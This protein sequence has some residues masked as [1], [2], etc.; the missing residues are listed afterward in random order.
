[1][2]KNNKIDIYLH[3][4]SLKWCVCVCV[5]LSR[6][7]LQGPSLQQQSILFDDRVTDEITWG[8]LIAIATVWKEHDLDHNGYVVPPK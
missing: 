8:A 6:N 2:T 7:S 5:I 3:S 1:M 4:P